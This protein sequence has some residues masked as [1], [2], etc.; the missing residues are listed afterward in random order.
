M[1][2]LYFGYR[3]SSFIKPLYQEWEGIE[4]ETADLR[5]EVDEKEKG[6]DSEVCR[7]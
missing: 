7:A 3:S 4:E 2:L 1:T 5:D 6:F